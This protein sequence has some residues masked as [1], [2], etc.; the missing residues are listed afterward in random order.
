MSF[1]KAILVTAQFDVPYAVAGSGERVLICVNGMQQTMAVWRSLLKRTV[2]AGFRT[3]LFDFPHQGRAVGRNGGEVLTLQQQVD[4]LAGVVDHVVP[5]ERVALIGGSWGSL[6][7]AAYAATHPN[8]VS[9][10]VLGSFQTRPSAALREVAHRGR[11]L[12]AQGCLDDLARLFISEFGDGIP[13]V[14]REQICRQFRSLQPEQM[15]QM[16]DQGLQLERGDDFEAHFDL[17][18]ITAP[19]LLVNGDLDPLIDRDN[20]AHVLGQMRSAR[21]HVEPG[22]G[23]FLHFERPEIVETYVRFLTSHD[24][25]PEPSETFLAPTPVQVTR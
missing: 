6:V 13:P 16:S 3:V 4:V 24:E 15:Q 21:L 2:A 20:T 17:G 14:R 23:H 9:R 8:R 22:T 5:F 19:T 18:R 25:A 11:S 1:T 12:I 7:A 10:M